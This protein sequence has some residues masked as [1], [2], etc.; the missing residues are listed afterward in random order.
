[1]GVEETSRVE[2]L[3]RLAS[4]NRIVPL[5]FAELWRVGH[6]FF[7][8]CED[9]APPT[10]I[11]LDSSPVGVAVLL[12]VLPGLVVARGP[13]FRLCFLTLIF[14]WLIFD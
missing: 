5:Y 10:A 8:A 1:M 4:Y 6:F 2:L 11:S 12:D 3:D 7:T 13:C 14:G 9:F